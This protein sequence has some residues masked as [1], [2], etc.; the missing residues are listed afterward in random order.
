MGTRRDPSP[1]L[2]SHSMCHP[3]PTLLRGSPGHPPPE[4]CSVPCAWGGMRTVAVGQPVPGC[5]R[6]PL[7]RRQSRRVSCYPCFCQQSWAPHLL[8]NM[9]SPGIK[10]KEIKP[11][12]VFASVCSHLKILTL[13]FARLLF[14]LM[15]MCMIHKNKGKNHFQLG[16]LRSKSFTCPDSPN[17]HFGVFSAPLGSSVCL[18]FNL[19]D[20]WR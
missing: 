5:A 17:F 3:C 18:A 1:T 8:I 15:E 4:L 16:V 13:T 19:K 12:F 10:G 9:Q 7:P 2:P 6:A 11:L 14:K 20:Y